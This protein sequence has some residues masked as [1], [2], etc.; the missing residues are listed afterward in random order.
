MVSSLERE[1]ASHH[2]IPQRSIIARTSSLLLT[3]L[4]ALIL[5]LTLL[6]LAA[7]GDAATNIDPYE[8]YRKAMKPEF[9][10]EL[11]TLG[12]LPTYQ[13]SV[14]LDVEANLLN[15]FANINVPNNSLDLWDTLVFRLYPMLGQYG[16]LM[17]IQSVLVDNQI[18]SFIYQPGTQRTA[19]RVSL[20]TPLR[21]KQVAHVQMRWK[22][23][24]PNWPDTTDVYALFGK[25]QQMVSLPLFYPA[26]A[27]YQPNVRFGRGDWWTGIGTVRGDSAF[28][29][30]SLFWVT[31]TLPAN[32]VPVA[33]GTLITS[34]F[35]NDGQSRHV[36]V[37]GPSREFLLHTSP[38]FTSVYTEAYGTRV[39][40]YWLP[41]D[42]AAGR[43]AL[44]YAVASLRIFSDEYG[45]YPFRDMSVAPA[46]LSYRGMEYPQV[47][48]IGVEA[49][50]RFRNSLESLVAHEV[51]HQWWYQIVHNDPVNEPWLDEALAE[52][53]IKLYVEA[54][55]GNS[56]AENMQYSR[57]Q[58]RIDG[59]SNPGLGLDHPVADF[60]SNIVYETIVYS[61]GALFYDAIRKRLGSRKFGDFLQ[62][63]FQKHRY[64]IV[65]TAD[66]MAAIEALGDP[67]ITQ[68]A[69]DWIQPRQ[70]KSAEVEGQNSSA[71]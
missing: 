27:V 66:W 55:Y 53:S 21:S 14:T 36:W 15:G 30:A 5:L 58:T 49:Y 71:P 47:S 59:L 68:L 63:Y 32:Y 67:T 42:E 61:K 10:E 6:M 19:L 11:D 20:P 38:Q 69:Q 13:L 46:P 65:T 26:L 29:D 45:P 23:E 35:V 60:D 12:P 34:T 62:E 37:T 8:P 56:S 40:S 3:P 57:W 44:E 17:T 24:I 25:S 28:G 39:T 4:I 48:L 7:C 16:G 43:A 70:A 64:G 41:G 1:L 54:L 22:V 33:S 18:T 52:Y 51:A 2:R 9:R 50:S 31:A